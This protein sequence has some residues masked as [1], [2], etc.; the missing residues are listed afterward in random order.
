MT[1]NLK[2]CHVTELPKAGHQF[3]I[4][5][6]F[7]PEK[8]RNVTFSQINDNDGKGDT[9]LF[10][11]NNVSTRNLASEVKD[12]ASDVNSE[13]CTFDNKQQSSDVQ[14]EDPLTCYKCHK[15]FPSQEEVIMHL[16]LI[17]NA[18]ATR[19]CRKIS[20]FKM[21]S[22]V[23]S[24]RGFGCAVCNKKFIEKHL[25]LMHFN[26][27]INAA[28]YVCDI[29]RAGFQ[30]RKHLQKHLL[31][32]HDKNVTLPVTPSQSKAV[33]QRCDQCSK[34]F[35]LFSEF[36]EHRSLC[37]STSYSCE[38]CNTVFF[39]ST[40]LENHKYDKH[41]VPIRGYS[42]FLSGKRYFCGICY[43]GFFDANALKEH[44]KCHQMVNNHICD[45]CHSS[46]DS[47]EDLQ[48]HY[49][50]HIEEHYVLQDVIKQHSCSSC[51]RTFKTLEQLKNH[52][53]CGS[54]ENNFMKIRDNNSLVCSVKNFEENTNDYHESPISDSLSNNLN[55]ENC[56]KDKSN[57]NL[58]SDIVNEAISETNNQIQMTVHSDYADANRDKSMIVSATD[59]ENMDFQ[60]NDMNDSQTVLQNEI[61]NTIFDIANIPVIALKDGGA[62]LNCDDGYCI[63]VIDLKSYF[64]LQR[65]ICASENRMPDIQ[66]SEAY[67]E[68]DEL[69]AAV[70]QNHLQQILAPPVKNIEMLTENRESKTDAQQDLQFV[71]LSES[72]SC[73]VFENSEIYSQSV[74]LQ[75]ESNVYVNQSGEMFM[76]ESGNVVVP[77]NSV[78]DFNSEVKC[79]DVMLK[80]KFIE[81]QSSFSGITPHICNIC[82]QVFSTRTSLCL[83]MKGSHTG[84]DCYRCGQ[85]FNSD[86]E[87]VEHEKTAHQSSFLCDLC[88]VIF[89]KEYLLKKHK[90]SAHGGKFFVCDICD[91]SY[92]LR[93]EF[94]IH[95][96]L[97]RGET[98]PT[99]CDICG[100]VYGSVSN[101]MRHRATHE[102]ICPPK[103]YI[104]NV[105]DK[106]FTA[107]NPLKK[108]LITHIKKTAYSYECPKCKMYFSPKALSIHVDL[109]HAE[110]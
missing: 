64:V 100:K 44:I 18:C 86:L 11:V 107:S 9:M 26:Q 36:E 43:M 97:H 79:K 60:L 67:N 10:T 85:S 82:Q 35:Q 87:L 89:T 93:N 37:D 110:S 103:K 30:Q 101:Y 48:V 69:D 32:V 23:C 94:E 57:L 1:V 81:C 40:Q 59:Y 104:C 106:A 72:N 4:H 21:H 105:C 29:C 83:H 42:A 70:L 78:P 24:N 95:L 96:M 92:V 63:V 90:R 71:N 16:K 66:N 74:P 88:D 61:S 76:N 3:I 65:G 99:R 47:D 2:T 27:H 31:E 12:I 73:N 54:C 80:D 6:N 7:E 51:E 45:E 84:Y 8:I 108:H 53:E 15:S 102:G 75:Q 20:D 25:L 46:F 109:H 55:N 91:K 49:L 77:Q 19:D 98:P 62:L 50:Q 22:S 38:I 28:F 58:V 39:T 17:H 56:D 13:I 5:S 41:K 33:Y 34:Y 52:L 68:V 14:D